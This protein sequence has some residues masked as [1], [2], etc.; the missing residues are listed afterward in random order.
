MKLVFWI[1][2]TQSVSRDKSICSGG[3]TGAPTAVMQTLF[4]ILQPS[5]HTVALASQPLL[6]SLSTFHWFSPLD[7]AMRKSSSVAQDKTLVFF[8]L[9]LSVHSCCFVSSVQADVGFR[10]ER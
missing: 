2:A 8:V 7:I 4:Q 10:C 5:L 9:L 1:L 3:T 6:F